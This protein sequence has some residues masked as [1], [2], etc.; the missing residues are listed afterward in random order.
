MMRLQD[1]ILGRLL[2]H[3]YDGDAVEFTHEDHKHLFLAK[4]CLY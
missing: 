3:E 2:G 1:H 4:Y